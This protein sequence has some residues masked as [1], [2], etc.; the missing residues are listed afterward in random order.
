MVVSICTRPRTA[1]MCAPSIV[2]ISSWHFP[3]LSLSISLVFIV[4]ADCKTYCVSTDCFHHIYSSCKAIMCPEYRL[5]FIFSQSRWRCLCDLWI[6]WV[7]SW[8]LDTPIYKKLQKRTATW[9]FKHCT[10]FP[11]RQRY[12]HL[13]NV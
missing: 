2:A 8:A 1:G 3:T 10:N 12:I 5:A 11:G 9:K 7:W 13:N 4:R 6:P